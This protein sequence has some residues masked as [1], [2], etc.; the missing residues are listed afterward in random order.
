MASGPVFQDG[1]YYVIPPTFYDQV[2]A[3][4]IYERVNISQV[5]MCDVNAT[6]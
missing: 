6:E 2:Y 5:H 1:F 4:V 3:L